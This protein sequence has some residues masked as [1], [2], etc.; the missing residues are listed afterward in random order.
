MRQNI[1]GVQLVM[2]KRRIK[3]KYIQCH[4]LEMRKVGERENKREE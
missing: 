2:K 3:K 1:N 4:S